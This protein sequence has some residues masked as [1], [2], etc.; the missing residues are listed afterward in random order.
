MA[1]GPNLAHPQ[2]GFTF[3]NSWGKYKKKDNIL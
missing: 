3:L 2:D 1:H